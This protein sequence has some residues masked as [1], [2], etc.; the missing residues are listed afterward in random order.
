MTSPAVFQ[1]VLEA[2]SPGVVVVDSEG[3]VAFA[4]SR[5]R[6]G[7]GY[8]RGEFVGR[9]LG[10]L[11]PNSNREA[12]GV[13]ET[14]PSQG[15]ISTA[16][17]G[18]ETISW[19]RTI[20]DGDDEYY[21]GRLPDASP[22]VDT[23]FEADLAP[24][25]A[26]VEHFPNGLVTLFD[27]DLRYLTVGGDRFY[28][29]DITPEDLQGNRLEDVLPQ[30]NVERLK[31]AYEAALDGEKRTTTVSL[32]G[33]DIRVHVIPVRNAAGEVV[34]GMTMSQDITDQ[35][36]RE[37]ELHEARTRYRTLVEDA[38]VP[39][40]IGDS[41]GQLVEVNA[42]AEELL[43][44][45]RD[46]LLGEPVTAL[47]PPADEAAYA[48]LFE[49]HRMTGGTRRYRPNGEQV[50]VS[51]EDGTRIP[52]E[53]S[54]TNVTVDGEPLTLGMFRDISEQVWYET[55]L[56]ELHENAETLLQAET[57]VEIA[58]NLVQTATEILDLDLVSVTLYDETAGE[59]TPAAYSDDLAEIMGAPPTLPI[60]GSVAGTVFVENETVR[61]DD[62]RTRSEVYNDQTDVRSQL[63][64]PIDEF[65]VIISGD[66]RPGALGQSD[67]RLL[68]LLARHAEAVF[69]RTARE[70]A[71]R[72]R[73]HELAER[74]ETLEAVEALN[75]QLR[76]LI[77]IATT[78]ETPT[79]LV[80]S[81]CQLMLSN[82]QFTFAW[83]GHPTESNEIEP[84]AWAGA[85]DGYL[86]AVSFDLSADGDAPAVRTARTGDVT[87]VSNTARDVQ[88]QPWRR[89]AVRRGFRS[90]VSVPIT[91]QDALYGVLTV[92]SNTQNVFSDR[93][94]ETF[95][96]WASLLGSV[97]NK[98]ER[99]NAIMAEYGTRA[100]Y[101]LKSPSCPLVRV[102]QEC[103]G[104]LDFIGLREQTEG[105]ESIFVTV[106]SELSQR[107][108]RAARNARSISDVTQVR[109]LRSKTLYRVTI[110]ESS[111]ATTLARFGVRLRQIT[112]VSDDA[113][114]AEVLL[115]STMPVQR[116]TDLV[117]QEYPAAELDSTRS[118]EA[119][120][121][122]SGHV[123]SDL[124][125]ELTERQ[126]DALELAYYGGYFETPKGL[127][128][129]DI[130]DQMGISSSSFHN[131]LH[132]AQQTVFG[133]LF[134]Q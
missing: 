110:T 112:G 57:D 115:P 17:G 94:E 38:P 49:R 84:D 101:E 109:T 8:G 118:V 76:E 117:R 41:T 24:Y 13:P 95:R 55:A 133:A 18:T 23:E 125:T 66:T 27:S 4:D 20:T 127:S 59:L 129:S 39:I 126:R 65:G 3:V 81:A 46:D 97:L 53:I 124:F 52:V 67:Q 75:N 11:G 14:V 33:R 128:G 9:Q 37:R 130:A 92:F 111:I 78:A 99:T 106:P 68:E 61:T 120:L 89:E 107:F 60:E 96:E 108:E 47:H 42:A 102:V 105:S 69:E 56:E 15:A 62:V 6:D 131:H 121:T 113:V 19:I 85:E 26:L 134:E 72:Q 83:I 40:F 79:E 22:D 16:T 25:R 5:M 77:Q 71:L 116:V 44:R 30:E 91:Y 93:L 31:P 82:D 28:D 73:E 43:D 2:V 70:Q 12:S 86:D 54:V 90:V 35:R 100:T 36:E 10:T 32:E 21:L 87:V 58:E 132:A 51:M 45:S 123:T 63:I 98:I 122:M 1:S 103:A 50:Y 29:F 88:A 74:A 34:A 114:R 104:T 119:G 48:E 80:E 64:V 7:L